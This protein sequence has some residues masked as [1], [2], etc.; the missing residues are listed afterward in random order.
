MIP[1]QQNLND[2]SVLPIDFY[3]G[4]R[5]IIA[6]M[7]E[8]NS[9]E[10]FSD[11]IIDFM[12]SVSREILAD[13]SAREFPDVIT[14]AFWLRKASIMKQKERFVVSTKAIRR[15]RGIVL[16][17]APSNVPVNYAYS[18]FTGLVCGNANIVRIPTKNFPQV[19]LI[20]CAINKALENHENIKPYIALI[21]YG[22]SA[23]TN[24]Y[25]SSIAD[26]RVIWGGDETIREIRE[27]SLKPRAT[28]ITFA[29]RYSLAVIDSDTYMAMDNKDR[30]ANDFYNDTFLTDQNACTSP[31][32][33]IWIGKRKKEAQDV[34]W[35]ELHSIVEKKYELQGVQAVNKLTSG[36]LLAVDRSCHR[37]PMAD[38]LIVRMKVEK[39]DSEIMNLKDNSGYF[40]EYDCNNV[41]DMRE[42]CNNERCQTISYIGNTEVLLPLIRS[43]IKGVD[44]IV[45]IGKSMNFDFIWDGYDLVERLTRYTTY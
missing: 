12:N 9:M 40:F 7:N 30:I 10:T 41:V 4:S 22:H 6:G 8:I 16:H 35:S 37:I 33:V 42:V 25:L 34:F 14:L 2:I 45:E 32:A 19:E 20:N 27:F 11:E 31:R 38:N 24:R 17:I 26:V 39:L 18:L 28:E 44:R 3:S 36:Y 23:E 5:E 43:G 21:K 15:G 13:V 1:M 29:D